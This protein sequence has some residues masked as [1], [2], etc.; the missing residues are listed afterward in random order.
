MPYF[1]PNQIRKRIQDWGMEELNRRY[2]S[3]LA[4]FL[5]E[6]IDPQTGWMKLTSGY[7]FGDAARV[8]RTLF[9]TGD[10][11][12]LGRVIRFDMHF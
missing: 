9:M 11:P 2:Q 3:T 10:Q 4:N 7:G 5:A 6:L 1:A 12:N 8:T